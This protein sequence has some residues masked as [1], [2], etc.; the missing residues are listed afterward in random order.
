[1]YNF[2]WN[3][4]VEGGKLK[5]MHTMEIPFAFDQ[6][7]NA[8]AMT[9]DGPE[10]FALAA[11]VSAAWA[12]FARTGDPS[13]KGIGKWPAFEASKRS[14]MIFDNECKVKADPNHEERLALAEIRGSQQG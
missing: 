12:A 13:H 9:G 10:A 11:K 5:S 6:I 2:A 3:S 4:P 8:K 14:T 7:A 1:M